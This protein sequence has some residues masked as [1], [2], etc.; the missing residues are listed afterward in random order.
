MRYGI[1]MLGLAAAVLG[2]VGA[3]GRSAAAAAPAPLPVSHTVTNLAGWTVR[4]DERL[5]AGAEAM[6]GREATDLLADR[7]NEIAAVMAPDRLER[8]RKVVIQ[9][10]LTHGALDNMQYHPNPAWLRDHGYSTGLAK[11]VHIPV[12]RRFV[13]ARHRHTQPWCVLHEL[14]HAYHD[15]VL[16]FNEPRIS[17]AWK[18]LQEGGRYE[19]VAFIDGGTRRHYA[20]T[21]PMEAFAEMSE[22]YFGMNDFFPFNRAELKREEP[23]L[24]GLLREVWGPL[25]AE[26]R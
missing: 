21:D 14:A 26:R 12:A 2:I 15:Q 20:L 16:G 7:L 18:A 22:A 4:L 10:D 6:L 11:C 5:R 13:D 17:E 25:P 24:Y 1:L 19:S 8:L 23:V 3:P 9:L